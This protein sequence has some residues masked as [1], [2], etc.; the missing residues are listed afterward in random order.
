MELI[1]LSKQKQDTESDLFLAQKAKEK[2]RYDE[3][4]CGYMKTACENYHGAKYKLP[5]VEEKL[6]KAVTA[7]KEKEQTKISID[8]AVIDLRD[9][10]ESIHHQELETRHHSEQLNIDII[11]IKT[12]LQGFQSSLTAGFSVKVSESALNGANFVIDQL[13]VDTFDDEQRVSKLENIY[14]EAT[15]LAKE[16]LGEI[17][18]IERGIADIPESDTL[19]K[20]VVAKCDYLQLVCKES[21][22]ALS[23]TYKITQTSI[24]AAKTEYILFRQEMLRAAKIVEEQAAIISGPLQVD[25]HVTVTM[26][27]EDMFNVFETQTGAIDQL[28][29]FDSIE[30]PNFGIVVKVR[31][32]KDLRRD[33]RKIGDSWASG[34]QREIACTALLGGILFAAQQMHS[35]S[36]IVSHGWTRAPV[37]LLDEPFKN[38]DIVNRKRLIGSML[39]LPVQMIVLYPDAPQEIIDSSDVVISIAQTSTSDKKT[40]VKLKRGIRKVTRSDIARTLRGDN[41]FELAA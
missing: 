23:D 29:S 41:P 24:S 33:F 10:L 30:K 13:L 22:V 17:K 35:Q 4:E 40:L 31:F 14:R 16:L 26:P 37:L 32:D 20:S 28:I 36:A 1:R 5:E 18:I 6:T 34:G 21:E 38:L 7:R 39:L 19:D 15:Q 8:S 27:E 9:Q 11:S 2:S 12:S 3:N 25:F